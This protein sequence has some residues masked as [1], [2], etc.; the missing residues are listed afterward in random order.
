MP[1]SNSISSTFRSDSGNR[2]YIRTTRRIT[3]VGLA[4]IR[5]RVAELDAALPGLVDEDTIKAARRELRYW[6]TRQSTAQLMGKGDGSRVSFGCTVTFQMNRRQRVIT[7]VGDDEA[8]P[9]AGRLSFSAPLSRALMDAEPGETLDFTNKKD[10]IEVISIGIPADWLR[11]QGGRLRHKSP[12]QFRLYVHRDKRAAHAG[13]TQSVISM[14]V[15][16]WNHRAVWNGSFAPLRRWPKNIAS[17]PTACWSRQAWK[18]CLLVSWPSAS[19]CPPP[20]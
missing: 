3:S 7:I 19:G 6:S 20:R 17:L 2:T 15:E 5:A 12:P 8:D 11:G 14:I 9:A 16:I 4:Q 10:A 1:R 18:A 13:L